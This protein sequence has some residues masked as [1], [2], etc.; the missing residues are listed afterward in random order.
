MLHFFDFMFRCY[1]NKNKLRKIQIENKE[2]IYNKYTHK[3]LV[4]KKS[5][6]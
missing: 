4:L 2:I 3:D 6:E 5:G 1:A